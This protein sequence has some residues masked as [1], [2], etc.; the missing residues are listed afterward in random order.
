M[1]LSILP[2]LS[3]AKLLKWS[4]VKAVRTAKTANLTLGSLSIS[5][6]LCCSKQCMAEYAV[7]H[8]NKIKRSAQNP[9]EKQQLPKS[10]TRGNFPSSLHARYPPSIPREPEFRAW[11]HVMMIGEFEDSS[12]CFF[13]CER[14]LQARRS[15]NPHFRWTHE[16]KLLKNTRGRRVR[17]PAFFRDMERFKSTKCGMRPPHGSATWKP[18]ATSQN[19][20]YAMF[21]NV[22]DGI[23]PP[24]SLTRPSRAHRNTER[25]WYP[26]IS[27][28][29]WCVLHWEDL[30]FFTLKIGR[31]F[32]VSRL[33]HARSL[34]ARPG[35]SHTAGDGSCMS[36]V[37]AVAG[38][39]LL[40]AHLRYQRLDT[41]EWKLLDMP[42]TSAT[43]LCQS[44]SEASQQNA[45]SG[46]NSPCPCIDA[47]LHV[48]AASYASS[49]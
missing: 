47:L 45:R 49:T 11:E 19:M 14:H 39:P 25:A 3:P 32:A 38:H 7:A 34:Q 46:A 18:A 42:E 30:A 43:R 5:F 23:R 48:I 31:I 15:S 37:A 1:L 6:A 41:P 8:T 22:W 29:R 28:S 27:T 10:P 9:Y 21:G 17:V 24:R 4:Q 35:S 13:A 12:D 16:A 20:P 26:S 40:S 2:I 36:V 33:Q 44:L